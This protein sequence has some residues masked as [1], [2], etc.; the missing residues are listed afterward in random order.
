MM[1]KYT[2]DSKQKTAR[3]VLLIPKKVNFRQVNYQGEKGNF[4]IINC[5]IH[6]KGITVLNVLH[7]INEFKIYEAKPTEMQRDINK[8]K[9]IFG[10]FN[11]LF[12]LLVE[13]ATKYRRPEQYK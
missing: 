5:F 10:D 7:H 11:T 12:Q 6:Q 2:V 13:Q 3:M 8:H 4:L 9:S 1:L